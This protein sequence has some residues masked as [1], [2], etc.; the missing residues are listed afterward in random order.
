MSSK[1]AR[2][3]KEILLAI[4]KT[5]CVAES[6]T[7]GNLQAMITSVS[8]SSDYFDGGVTAYNIH[9]KVN[10]LGVDR[11]HA[12]SVNCVSQRVA[13]EMAAGVRRLFGS[14]IGLATTG[15]AEPWPAG[16]VETPF[17]FFAINIGGW[18]TG[19]RIEGG[20]RPRVEV[21]GFVADTVMHRLIEA[22]GDLKRLEPAPDGLEEVQRQLRHR[23]S[24]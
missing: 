10:L 6:L 14:S 23:E 1:P 5:I 4:D 22:F 8:G 2:D 12:D 20:D 15:Y 9:Q 21:Q 24:A 18:T 11:E 16:S 17:A 7:G 3:L 19:D 13:D